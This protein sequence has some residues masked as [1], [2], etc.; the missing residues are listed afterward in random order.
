MVLSNIIIGIIQ[1]IR[2]KHTIDKLSLISAPVAQVVREGTLKTVA[3]E[4]LV[5]DDIVQLSAGNQICADAVVA[6][7]NVEVNEALVTGESDLVAKQPG[8]PLLSGSFV[9]VSYTHLDV[10]KR[11]ERISAWHRATR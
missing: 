6:E 2:A 5:L 9:A 7:G 8:D 10:Y 4:Q 11:Q 3:I 1:E